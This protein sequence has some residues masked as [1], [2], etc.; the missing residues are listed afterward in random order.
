[1]TGN[2]M[3]VQWA[4]FVGALGV[5]GLFGQLFNMLVA[6]LQRHGYDE[7]FTAFEVV[8]G[9]LVTLL[10]MAV[11]LWGRPFDAVSLLLLLGGFI[12]SGAPMIGGSWARYAHLRAQ[13]QTA[14]RHDRA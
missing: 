5:L 12:A 6:F 14:L 7:G 13:S 11:P 8:A 2:T 4:L 3:G 10:V 9:T 1:M